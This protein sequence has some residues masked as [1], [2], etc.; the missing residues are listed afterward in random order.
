MIP[1]NSPEKFDNRL[2]ISFRRRRSPVRFRPETRRPGRGYRL[3]RRGR[4][5]NSSEQTGRRAEE[6]AGVR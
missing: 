3:A 2:F 1:N 6:D 4:A 5:E